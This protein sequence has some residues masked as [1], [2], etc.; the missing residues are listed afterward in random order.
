MQFQSARPDVIRAINQRWLLQFWNDSR[1]GGELPQWRDLEGQD[2][3]AMSAN[4]SFTDVVAADGGPRFLIRYHGANIGLAYGSDCHG[5]YL[6]Q[7]LPPT[8][9]EPALATYRQVVAGKVPVYTA[10]TTSDSSGRLVHY[11]RLLL[12]FAR[13]G[14]HVDRILASLEMVSLDGAFE[15]NNLMTASHTPS[16]FALCATIAVGD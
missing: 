11:E 9:R 5:K 10:F 8:F 16:S 7:I 4:L 12:P 1:G 3:S 6:D 14:L 13:E 15:I 2:L